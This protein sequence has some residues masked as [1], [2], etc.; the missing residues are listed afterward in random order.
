MRR[1]YL[2]QGP[3]K[4]GETTFVGVIVL[5]GL[6]LQ[7]LKDESSAHIVEMSHSEKYSMNFKKNL[8]TFDSV[9]VNKLLCLRMFLCSD[10]LQYLH[11][12]QHKVPYF[13]CNII[14]TILVVL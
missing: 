14:L 6:V 2:N 4:S 1:R 3:Q 8:L 13:C 9:I 11:N 5:H 10:Y 7:V 12:A